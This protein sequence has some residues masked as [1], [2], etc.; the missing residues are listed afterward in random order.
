MAKDSSD[1]RENV[2][3]VA[4]GYARLQKILSGEEDGEGAGLSQKD[5]I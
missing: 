4:Q 1:A 3:Q 5:R 2:N